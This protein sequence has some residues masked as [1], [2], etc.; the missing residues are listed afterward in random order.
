[1]LDPRIYRTA[2]AAV[3]LMVIVFAFSLENEPGGRHTAL[4]PQAFNGGAAFTT[5]NQLARDY[6]N[7]QPGS[8]TDTN[9]A[10]KIGGELQTALG[11]SS[12]PTQTVTVP[13]IDG[14]RTVTTVTAVN[15]GLSAGTIIVVAPRDLGSGS[16]RA[17]MSA[18]AV[19]VELAAVVHQ[20]SLKHSVMF[21]ST[22]GSLGGGAIAQLAQQL[23]GRPVDAVIV[24]GDLAA[25]DPSQPV[26]VPWSGGD[27][28]APP[29]LRN[30]IASALG[31]RAL[32]GSRNSGIPAQLAR[33]AFPMTISAQGPLVAG[34]LPAVLVSLSGERG[35]RPGEAI[36]PFA[37]IGGMG[38]AMLQAIDALDAGQP[39]PPPSSYLMLSSKIVPFWAVRLLVLALLLPI[40]AVTVDG[41]ARARRRGHTVTRWAGWV[42]AGAVP[43]I[44]GVFVIKA[45]KYTHV[46]GVAPPDPVGAGVIPLDASGLVVLIAVALMI[47]ASFA[48]VRPA[49]IHV[50]ARVSRE[51]IPRGE[52]AS[53]RCAG[54]ALLL[55]A[56]VVALALWWRNPYAAG[57]LVPAL[58]LWVWVV[59]PEVRIPRPVK[60]VMVLIG[61]IPPALV[62]GYYVHAFGLSATGVLW[63]GVLLIAGGHL[64][65]AAAL[66]WSVVLGCLAGAF[67]I[68]VQPPAGLG[69]DAPVV[70]V[71]GPVTYAA[72]GSLGGTRSALRR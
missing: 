67:V 12:L 15:P 8:I 71:R 72:P 17:G 7:P 1:M 61:L 23:A 37:R 9:L 50:S 51:S 63:N 28:L 58:H 46:I 21:V 54:P 30:T 55:I 25:R 57:L 35:P 69:E 11:L 29:A 5:M 31:S 6:P 65:V 48:L 45:A 22:S 39:I 16:P 60:L 13:T 43:F 66:A 42:L 62:I 38:Q 70:T 52:D 19:L 3:L 41:V 34:G 2:L 44:L 40:L 47:V 32:V 33:L 49:I 36:G 26:V 18:S 14:T 4:A 64:G 27:T 20:Q 10:T 56:S 59:D 68:A 53:T 24:L